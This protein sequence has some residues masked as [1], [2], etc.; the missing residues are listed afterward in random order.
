MYQQPVFFL[1]GSKSASLGQEKSAQRP[2]A[3]ISIFD[4][5][6]CEGSENSKDDGQFKARRE[7]LKSGLPESFK[8]QIAKTV[9]SK[10]AYSVSCSS[11]HPVTH[12]TQ[13][14]DGEL[15]YSTCCLL[16]L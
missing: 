8:K 1:T 3:V 5:S 15:L 9:A 6:S 2:S 12:T 4:D 14:P 13:T 7:F 11:F 16:L 10:E